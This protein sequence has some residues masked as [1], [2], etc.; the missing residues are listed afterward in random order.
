MKKKGK[1]A[2]KKKYVAYYRVSTT[3]QGNSGL[4]LEAQQ[5]SVAQFCKNNG[6][7]IAE[8]TEVESGKKDN[9]PTLQQAIEFAKANK[10]TLVI[11]RLDRLSRN[12]GF[13]FS[14]IDSGVD[15]VACDLPEFN[16]LTLAVFAGMAQ[17]EREL[18]SKRT[19]EGLAR[20]K[21]KLGNPKGYIPR[22]C[23]DQAARLKKDR[24]MTNETN[25]QAKKVIQMFLKDGHSYRE[26]AR[27]LNELG[28]KTVRGKQWTVS[29]V[30][31]IIKMYDLK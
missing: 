29:N 21:K 15:I 1:E 20:S 11:A 6:N 4:G 8:Y 28:L 16:T 14:L 10:A 22:A 17:H 12:V 23:I 27:R 13:I 24:A 31:H 18:I 25:L 19:K 30:Q 5:V 7:I 3:S 2:N 9:R 26:I